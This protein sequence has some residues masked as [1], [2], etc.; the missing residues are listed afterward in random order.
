MKRPARRDCQNKAI[1]Y[2]LAHPYCI[3]ALDP[4]LGKTRSSIEAHEES[5]RQNCLCI[6]PGYLID[7][8]VAE[9]NMWT[10]DKIITTF[11]SGK[12][13]YEVV[14]SDYV[15]ISYELSQKAPYLFEWAKTIII[16]ESHYLK[17]QEAKRTQFIHK[18]IYENSVPSVIQLTG[19]PIKNRVSEFYSLLAL[20]YYNPNVADSPFL[21]EFP[22]ALDFADRFSYRH[23][24]D[25]PVKWG[26]VKIVK[27][28]GMQNIPELKKYLKGRYLR[29]KATDA[30]LP[31]IIY[32]TFLVSN[33]A[34]LQL[35]NEFNDHFSQ[36]GKHLVKSNVKAEAALKKT[37]I[38]VQYC[39]DLLEQ[40]ETPIVIYSDHVEACE[41]MAK[42]FNTTA[43]TGK[44]DSTRRMRLAKE[45]QE[46]EGK[47]LCAT[48]GALSVGIDLSRAK[49]IIINDPSWV[50]GDLKQVRERIR[51]MGSKDPVCIHSIFGSPQDEKIYD[52]LAEKLE[53][54]EKV[55]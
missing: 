27:W 14:D 48:I 23:E 8:W 29:I 34:N 55:T 22:S 2:A 18:H 10:E 26:T 49:D 31:P 6:V 54:I 19:T 4:R 30:D 45:F 50:P 38:T 51:K 7:N 21:D 11:K 13:L 1:S 20:T 16:D 44:I 3:L 39:E 42:A 9:I 35:L 32:K 47:V 52:A 5:G 43:L 41:A 15:I 17:S 46:G 36:E 28:V 53:V 33:I 25:M 24:F 12:Q 40:I 37:P